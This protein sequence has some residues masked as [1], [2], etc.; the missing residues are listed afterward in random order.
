MAL[1]GESASRN[2]TLSLTTQPASEQRFL[3]PVCTQ[4]PPLLLLLL[5]GSFD[6]SSGRLPTAHVIFAPFTHPTH[7]A[8][9]SAHLP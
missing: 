4:L 3:Q 2:A 1:P 9:P 8:P 7:P 6:S 5:T